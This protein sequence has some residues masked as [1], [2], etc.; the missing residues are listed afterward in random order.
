[1]SAC[2]ATVTRRPPWLGATKNWLAKPRSAWL[3]K[4]I[5]PAAAP[6]PTLV[7]ITGAIGRAERTEKTIASTDLSRR[8]Q[9]EKVLPEQISH[10]VP[11]V[12]WMLFAVNAGSMWV[13]GP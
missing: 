5:V 13:R 12:I 3:G 4:S 1:M 9:P 2:L 10:A 8:L 6:G 11:G 7:V